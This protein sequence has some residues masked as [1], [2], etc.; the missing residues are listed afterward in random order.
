MSFAGKLFWDVTTT[1]VNSV[2]HP[3]GIAK[4]STNLGWGKGGKVTGNIV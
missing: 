1:K 2:L 4:L 3:T